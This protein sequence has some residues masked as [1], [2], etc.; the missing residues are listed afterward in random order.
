MSTAKKLML[1]D[2]SDPTLRDL[3]IENRRILIV[4]DEPALTETYVDILSNRKNVALLQPKSSR[5]AANP[6]AVESK[7]NAFRRPPPF[8]ITVCSSATEALSRAREAV[9]KGK[10]YAMGFFDVLLNDKID[11]IELVKLIFEIDPE[12]YAVFV[13]AYHDRTVDNIHEILGESASER[14]DYLNKPFTEGEILQKARNTV[15]IWNLKQ[16]RKQK[17]LQLDEATKR[18]LMS[19]RASSVAAVARSVGHEFGNILLQISGTAELN[20]D[21]EPEKMKKALGTIL[22]ASDT[23]SKILEKFKD[24]SRPASIDGEKK[25]IIL[26]DVID[27]ARQLMSHQFEKSKIT[28]CVIKREKV[29]LIASQTSLVQVLVNILINMTHVMP[30]GGQIDVSFEVIRDSVNLKIRDYGPGIPKDILPKIFDAFFTTK[31]DKGTG[32]GLSICKEIVEI[33][34]GGSITAYNHPIK[35]AEFLI[36]LPLKPPGEVK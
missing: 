24:L 30:H 19:D 5:V 14:W 21:A 36:E 25:K 7:Q 2:S 8:E 15:T 6:Q 11:G 17:T 27:E 28:F 1:S 22:S 12:M 23:A 18:L 33:E 31:G 9:E 3:T 29:E 32:L 20:Q 35:G 16:D 10:P 26:N 34:H 4:E 13:T